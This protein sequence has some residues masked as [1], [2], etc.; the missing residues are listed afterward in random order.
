MYIIQQDK[1]YEDVSKTIQRD[2]LPP[3]S[4]KVEYSHMSDITSLE[5][6]KVNS[7]K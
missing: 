5:K 6:F 3:G 1:V 7:D 2:S 4:Y